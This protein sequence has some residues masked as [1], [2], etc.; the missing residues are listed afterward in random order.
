[1]IATT[2][3]KHLLLGKKIASTASVT[4]KDPSASTYAVDGEVVVT[5]VFGNV[6]NATTVASVDRIVLVQSQGPTKPAI[7]SDVIERKKVTAYNVKAFSAAVEQ[8][9]YLGFNGTSGTIQAINSNNYFG[10]I[11]WQGEALTYGNRDMYTAFE[12]TSDSAA[13]V[14]EVALGL[15]ESAVLNTKKHADR[16][17]RVE[18]VSDGTFTASSGGAATVVY[19]ST[20]I[21]IVES[22]GAAADAGK[23][24][25]DASTFAVGDA[26][27][28]G[29]TAATDAVYIITAIS[30]AGTATCT[31]T[32]DTPFQGASATVAAAN[33]GH[34][35]TPTAWG[36]KFTALPKSFSAGA[37]RYS[38]VRFK[39]LAKD[40]G[41]TTVT[42][43]TGASE[44][45]GT[46][47]QVQELEF[48]QVGF[49]GKL[50]RTDV[51]TPTPRA[52][53][54]NY[55]STNDGFSLITLNYHDQGTGGIG[56][57]EP[58]LKE[59]IIGAA[60]GAGAV[61]TQFNAASTGVVTVLD[62]WLK[63]VNVF[64]A[65]AANL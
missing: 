28:I 47:E 41:T 29:G 40:F 48:F 7:K 18:R 59:V 8:V 55:L 26:I 1:M 63:T 46:T 3:V 19:N 25:A 21:T 6:L 56:V 31:I 36:L 13:T 39:I 30:G 57:T 5:D 64:P 33:V 62:E 50:Y 22:A 2:H 16:L 32:L 38:K 20:K 17:V 49:E 52:N 10:R 23:Y 35:S 9:T 11:L 4:A 34:V 12:Y 37:F 65:Q 54:V 53:A 27:R 42:N 45:S 44:G 58:S 24:N 60:K 43:A 51:P 14:A 61:G 15:H